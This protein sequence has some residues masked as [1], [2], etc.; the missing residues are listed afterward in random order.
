M[1][2]RG[3][4]DYRATLAPVEITSITEG[5]VAPLVEITERG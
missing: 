2:V 5:T 1:G 4:G 3:W